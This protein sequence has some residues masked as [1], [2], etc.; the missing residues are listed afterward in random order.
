MLIFSIIR[1]ASITG[2]V[3]LSELSVVT[4][5]MLLDRM[6]DRIVIFRSWTIICKKST[7]HLNFMVNMKLRGD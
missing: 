2:K 6:P 4:K 5:L 3:A 7:A 1:E